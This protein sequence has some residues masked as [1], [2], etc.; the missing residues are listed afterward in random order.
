MLRL[1]QFNVIVFTPR[2]SELWNSFN[3]ECAAAAL[4]LCCV[5]TQTIQTHLFFISTSC[6][7]PISKTMKRSL[8]LSGNSNI[9]LF[10]SLSIDFVVV[11]L[12]KYP[13]IRKN[14]L[15]LG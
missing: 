1:L 7:F 9:K 3:F 6:D 13:Y 2:V 8:A 15:S 4:G 10:I 12:S 14:L 5:K 11:A